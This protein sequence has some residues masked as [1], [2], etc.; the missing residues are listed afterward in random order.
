VYRD[1][2]TDCTSALT[3]SPEYTK[4]LFRRAQAHEALVSLASTVTRTKSD[5]GN[6]SSSGGDVGGE[7]IDGDGDGSGGGGRGKVSL[8]DDAF[9]HLEKALR[10]HRSLAVLEPANKTFA[11]AAQRVAAR[12]TAT[13]KA[14]QSHVAYVGK[15]RSGEGTPL[16]RAHWIRVVMSMLMSS[17]SVRAQLATAGR[18]VNH[19]VTI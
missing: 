13:R 11:A 1:A 16:D 18:F 17:R 8:L 15:L 12:V 3:L 5:D 7:W 2:I 6:G 10:D 4:A 14:R 9:D 19:Y